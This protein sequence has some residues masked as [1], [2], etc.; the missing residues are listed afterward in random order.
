MGKYI[1]SNRVLG[2]LSSF[3]TFCQTFDDLIFVDI[4]PFTVGSGGTGIEK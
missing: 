1:Q 3:L 2:K 4:S